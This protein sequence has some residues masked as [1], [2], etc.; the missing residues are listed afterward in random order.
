MDCERKL[1]QARQQIEDTTRVLNYQYAQACKY[2]ARAERLEDCLMA[3]YAL[4]DEGLDAGDA[5]KAIRG[6][7][8]KALEGKQS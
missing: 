8:N 5:W 4:Q 3:I 1:K 6:I 2:T 7:I